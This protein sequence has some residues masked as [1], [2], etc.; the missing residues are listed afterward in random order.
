MGDITVVAASET[1]VA[2]KSWT[3]FT[4]CTKKCDGTRIDEAVDLHLLFPKYSLL[5]C[6]SN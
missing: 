5:E 2:F 1:K 3:P 4:K 6:S